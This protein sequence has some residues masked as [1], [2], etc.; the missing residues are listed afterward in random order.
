M[1]QILLIGKQSD[2]YFTFADCLCSAIQVEC[3]SLD[4]T[5]MVQPGAAPAE[6]EVLATGVGP[7]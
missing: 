1:R 4:H 7:G 6:V 2:F 3:R 5:K